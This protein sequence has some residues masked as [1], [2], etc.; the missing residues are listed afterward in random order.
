M[1]NREW[2]LKNLMLTLRPLREHAADVLTEVQSPSS[3]HWP[4]RGVS[5]L[6]WVAFADAANKIIRTKGAINE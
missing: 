1:E 6:E 3:Y 2:A 5:D 4:R